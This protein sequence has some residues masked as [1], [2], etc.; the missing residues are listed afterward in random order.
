MGIVVMIRN[1]KQLRYF[2][3]CLLDMMELNFTDDI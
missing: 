3:E 2:L 1:N